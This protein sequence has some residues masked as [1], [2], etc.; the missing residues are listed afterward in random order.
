[1]FALLQLLQTTN[2]DCEEYFYDTNQTLSSSTP[3][4]KSRLR[5]PVKKIGIFEEYF[6]KQNLNLSKNML[7]K[8]N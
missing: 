1:M 3:S 5:E 2:G 7:H 6:L 8:S 4:P